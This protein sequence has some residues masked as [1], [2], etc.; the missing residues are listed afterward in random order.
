MLNGYFFFLSLVSLFFLAGCNENDHDYLMSEQN[1]KS[2]VA[3]MITPSL[4]KIIEAKI[5]LRD[6]ITGLAVAPVT[7]IENGTAHFVIEG[8]KINHP[9]LAELLPN[10]SGNLTY[11][12]EATNQIETISTLTNTPILRAVFQPKASAN[13]IAITALTE[14]AV[15]RVE[16]TSNGLTLKHINTA[17]DDIKNQ[18]SITRFN[19]NQAP[20]VIGSGDLANLVDASQSIQQRAYATYLTTLA[21]ESLRIHNSST[22]AYD[23]AKAMVDDFSYDGKFDA[24]GHPQ[25]TML[26]SVGFIHGWIN[27]EVN[28]YKQFLKLSDL[29][30]LNKWLVNFNAENPAI[31]SVVPM[32]SVSGLE[33]YACDDEFGLKTDKASTALISV[34]ILNNMKESIKLYTLNEQGVRYENQQGILDGFGLRLN[35]IHT[36]EPIVITNKSNQC[37]FIYIA[38]TATNKM[39]DL[40]INDT[41]ISEE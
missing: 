38:V 12:D 19:I 9:L 28:F 37:L 29:I 36:G 2:T 1:K 30:D 3:I 24:I 41:V 16:K 34:D 31:A 35:N 40:K 8:S 10:S 7:N 13:N 22:P 15:Q 20:L 27:W 5:V 33:E 21:K 14:A 4:G 23:I 17:Y 32:R 6:A 39:L 11:F 26:Y 18:L 25:N